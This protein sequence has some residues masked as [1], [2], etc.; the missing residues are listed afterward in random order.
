VLRPGRL[1]DGL[2]TRDLSSARLAALQPLL[3][4]RLAFSRRP[5]GDQAVDAQV[6]IQI[7][8][9]NTFAAANQPPVVPLLRCAVEKPGV[10]R[11]RR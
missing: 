9:M 8:P 11:E 6:F 7:W 3:Q 2:L 1:A 10:P 5:S 4:R